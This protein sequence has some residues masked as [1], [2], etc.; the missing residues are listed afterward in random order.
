M[1][2]CIFRKRKKRITVSAHKKLIVFVI[3]LL[4]LCCQAAP[5]KLSVSN[6]TISVTL[7]TAD[8]TLSV[9]DNRT[10]HTWQQKP[11]G[12]G[13]VVKSRRLDDGCAKRS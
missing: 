1:A 9:T 11:S 2:E 7:N 8:A 12:R 5:Q 4:C 10:G 6:A 13:K 3:L